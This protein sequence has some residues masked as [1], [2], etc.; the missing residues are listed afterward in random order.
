MGTTATMMTV[1]WF[2]FFCFIFKFVC[3][4]GCLQARALLWRSED[5]LQDLSLL[6]SE[7]W[8]SKSS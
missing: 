7:T 3:V 5:I 4:S 8:G 2:G 1:L 6:P